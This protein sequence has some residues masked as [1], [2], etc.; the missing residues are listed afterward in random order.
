MANQSSNSHNIYDILL[1]EFILYRSSKN[2]NIIILIR[3]MKAT[4]LIKKHY[5]PVYGTRKSSF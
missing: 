4:C 2:L 3:L 1:S 5:L